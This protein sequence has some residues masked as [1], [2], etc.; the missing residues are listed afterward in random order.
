[1]AKSGY[2][3]EAMGMVESTSIEK[4]KEA[5]AKINHLINEAYMRGSEDELKCVREG[6]HDDIR[7]CF[8]DTYMQ[9]EGDTELFDTEETIKAISA[10][11]KAEIAKLFEQIRN[12]AR[13]MI[14]PKHVTPWVSGEYKNKINDTE[15]HKVK[16]IDVEA[17][18]RLEGIDA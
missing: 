11:H 17:L 16:A 14:M 15:Y 7:K 9:T 2:S 4:H 18:T 10:W 8:R 12:E 13:D 1:M 5:K 6:G 3:E